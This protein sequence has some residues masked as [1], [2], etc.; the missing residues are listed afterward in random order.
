MIIYK[1]KLYHSITGRHI[2]DYTLLPAQIFPYKFVK[3][4]VTWQKNNGCIF[5]VNFVLK[6]PFI[7]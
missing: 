2:Y 4:I 6:I 5:S 1:K 3:M 7:R